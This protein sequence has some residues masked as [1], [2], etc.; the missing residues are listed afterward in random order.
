MNMIDRGLLTASFVALIGIALAVG[1]TGCGNGGII[2]GTAP[3]A[4]SPTPSP[5]STP[6][7]TPSPHTSAS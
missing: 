3:A 7:P 6:K 4:A 2:P 5:S 1:F